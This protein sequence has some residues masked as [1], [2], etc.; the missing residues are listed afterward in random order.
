MRIVLDMQACQGLNSRRGISEYSI[1]FAKSIIRNS[2]QHDI[3]IVLNSQFYES[4]EYIRNLFKNLLPHDHIHVIDLPMNT[5]EQS[6]KNKWRVKSSELIREYYIELLKPDVVHVSNIFEGFYDDVTTSTGKT[7]KKTIVAT[8]VYDLIPY[9][10]KELY[11]TNPYVTRWYNKKLQQLRESDILLSISEHTRNDCIRFL[12]IPEDRIINISSAV[13]DVFQKNQYS[14]DIID[15]ITDKYGINGSFILYVGGIDARKNIESLIKAYASLSNNDR[16]NHQLVIA[17]SIS[18]KQRK[19]YD[20]FI[21]KY[22]TNSNS[23]IFTGYVSQDELV[24][25]YNI[26]HLFIFPSLYEGF[27]LPVLEAMNCGAPV[28]GSNKSSIAEVINMS[29]ATFDP[30]SYQD[31]AEKIT[32]VLN[33]NKLRDKLIENSHKQVKKFSW[34]ITGIKALEEFKK[35]HD[36]ISKNIKTCHS[37][38]QR[39]AFIS[40]LPPEKSG[41][42]DYSAELLPELSR[43]YD[44]EIILDQDHLK[45]DYLNSNFIYRNIEWFEINAEKFDRIVYQFGNSPFHKHM[46]KL[47]RKYPG[48]VVL[49]DF[50]LSSAVAW[51]DSSQ[52]IP[53]V[54]RRELFASGSYKAL[55]YENQNDLITV[56]KKY[57]CNKSVIDKSIGVVVHSE[58]AIDLASIWYGTDIKEKF[59][60]IPQLHSTPEKLATNEAKRTLGFSEDDF[61]I[62]SFGYLAETKLNDRLLESWIASDTSK[63]KSC[64]LIFVGENHP[65]DYADKILK[66]IKQSGLESQ[67]RI[68]GF[69]DHELYNNYLSAADVAIQLR[70]HSRGETSRTVLDCLSF[71]V[72]V[73][74][75]AHG[76]M[77]EY[78]DN[79]VIKLDDEFED[80]RL[81]DKIN[82]IYDDEPKRLN[83]SRT[84]REFIRTYHHPSI[85]AS[86][87][88]SVIE[89]IYEHASTSGYTGLLRSISDL[90]LEVTPE[91]EDLLDIAN[92]ISTNFP[93]L[94]KRTIF[95]DISVMVEQD[96]RTGIERVVRSILLQLLNSD[97]DEY[98]IEPVYTK[99]D[100]GK[101][102]YAR[103]YVANFLGIDGN[104]LKDDIIDIRDKDIFLGLDWSPEHIS[105]SIDTLKYYRMIGVGIYFVLYDMIPLQR[106]EFFPD[107]LIEIYRNW[108]LSI[109]NISNGVVCISDTVAHEYT[110]WLE[111]QNEQ[112]FTV[113]NVGYFHLSSD[114]S[115]SKPTT[116]LPDNID[117]ILDTISTKQ[118][119]VMVGTIEPRKGHKLVLDAF[120]KLWAQEKQ[121]NLIIAGKIGWNVELLT[122]RIQKH[123]QL[124]KL[125]FMYNDCSDEFIEE[126]YKSSQVLILASEAEGFGL[127]LIEAAKLGLPVIARD[128]PVFR[129]IAGKNITY[130]QNDSSDDLA[131]KVTEWLNTEKHSCQNISLIKQI[132]WE[133]SARQLLDNLLSWNKS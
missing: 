10:H 109:S 124:N 116:G 4:V 85:I 35:K 16:S 61:L 120:E 14:D 44:I 33:N 79:I 21:K 66:I 68:T 82:K 89:N 110:S 27:G 59:F 54:L 121:I 76:S 2:A 111:E 97:N 117:E 87:Y 26:C 78:S 84:G 67:I 5:E 49:H 107:G 13:D 100:N 9:T 72:P 128:L 132:T 65:G 77:A 46:F 91:P 112:H 24:C 62:C 105:S 6:H 50:Y 125:L 60:Y 108:L 101:Y 75:N 88:A 70:T 127:P 1:G 115:A 99:L 55:L 95:I 23:V 56:L 25:L 122:K 90:D 36:A 106:P 20:R 43:I 11:L 119:F 37:K 51:L 81:S 8:T 12:D 39:L 94:R 15:L 38:K 64:F 3:R 69:V 130:F 98:N 126:L 17:C 53:G 114:I 92:C 133:E 47:L 102:H 113:E 19:H 118:T 31:I 96:L 80:T 42:S 103:K 7:S 40:P 41:I 86:K 74:L 57:P 18:D 131:L 83:L 123:V 63:H 28:I 58:H 71:G 48:I 104:G 129:E 34:D 73:I 93:V 45:G 30:H 32:H 22:I 29:E 52:Y